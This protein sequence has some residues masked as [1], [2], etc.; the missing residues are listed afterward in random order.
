[1]GRVSEFGARESGIG[2]TPSVKI[3]VSGQKVQSDSTICP[4]SAI[5]TARG[6]ARAYTRRVSGI[7]L[8][9]SREIRDS[10][11]WDTTMIL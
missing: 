7:P 8:R 3:A 11:Q 4:E 2:M 5:L 10:T 9:E 6:T 1:V